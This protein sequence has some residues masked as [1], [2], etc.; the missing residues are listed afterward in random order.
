MYDLM[1]F[2]DLME[3]ESDFKEYI[4]HRIGMYERDDFVFED[5]PVSMRGTILD[6]N[7]F[8]YDIF[9]DGNFIG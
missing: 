5:E 9:F 7:D 3:S 8:S 4:H 6:F 1:V 2:A